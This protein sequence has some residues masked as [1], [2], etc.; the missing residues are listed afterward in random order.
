MLVVPACTQLSQLVLSYPSLYSVVPACPSLY[1]VVQACTKLSQLV[2]SCP[3]LFHLVLGCPIVYPV[4]LP[5]TQ[6]SHLVLSCPT[7]YSIVPAGTESFKLVLSLNVNDNRKD[8]SART[9]NQFC[10]LT[11]KAATDDNYTR[12]RHGPPFVFNVLN[13]P[14][15]R[16]QAEEAN[17][18][19]NGK[20][21]RPQ[22]KRVIMRL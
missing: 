18:K 12:R 22:R 8:L 17:T 14:Q 6:L 5:R 11:R 7:L 16:K 19:G 9:W 4:V 20:E 10:G 21:S 1:S 2:L 15:S 3:H 13:A